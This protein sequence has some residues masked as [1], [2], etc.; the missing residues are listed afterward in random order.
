MRMTL[1]RPG[2][3][4]RERA[5]RRLLRRSA[6]FSEAADVVSLL[7]AAGWAAAGRADAETAPASPA[8]PTTGQTA[9]PLAQSGG[10]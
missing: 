10:E 4:S 8:A 5:L 2:R 3:F 1:L 9:R 6:R 7:Q